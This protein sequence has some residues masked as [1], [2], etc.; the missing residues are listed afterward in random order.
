MDYKEKVIALLNTKELSREQKEKLEEIF[1]E[2]KESE[3]ERIREALIEHFKWNVQQILNDFSNKE[4]I[5][6]LENQG[7]IIKEWSEMRFNNIQTELQEMVDLK[8]KTEQGEQISKHFELKAGHWYI[9]HRAFCCRADHLTVKEGERFMCEKDGVVKGFVI[10]EPEKYFKEVCVPAPMEDE[11][12][13]AWSEEDEKMRKAAIEACKYMVDNFENST[14]RYEEALA[15]LKKQRPSGCPEYCVM[16]NCSN[17]PYHPIVV[18]QKPADVSKQEDIE[19]TEFEDA[20]YTTFSDIWQDYML[21]KEINVVD[22]VREHSDELLKIANKQKP[23]E[24]SDEDE[25]LRKSC[26]AHIEDELERIRNDKYGHSEIISDL[27]ESCRERI[28]WLESLRPQNRWKPSDEQ[29]KALNEALCHV[30]DDTAIQISMLIG[31]LKK[32]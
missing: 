25:R 18:K 1:P 26:I 2:L 17:C 27:K 22:F 29:M 16:S 19:L 31:K 30:D 9:C 3:D 13:P 20:L 21:G 15:W 6:W 28:N 23:T 4:C 7:E 8:Q 24:W 11:S 14:Q 10:K 12:N 32:L 5:A